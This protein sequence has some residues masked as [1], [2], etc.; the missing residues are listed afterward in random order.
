MEVTILKLKNG[1]VKYKVTK[2]IP[3]LL[4]SETR[5]FDSPEEAEK[6]I[7]EGLSSFL[8]EAR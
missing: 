5:C 2:R 1:K 3:E 7:K 4:V 6:Q 8:E